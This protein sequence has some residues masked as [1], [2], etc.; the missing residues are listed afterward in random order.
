MLQRET[1]NPSDPYAVHVA[2]LHDTVV[3]G[4]ILQIISAAVPN[5]L[6]NPTSTMTTDNQMLSQAKHTRC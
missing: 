2:T 1:L 5:I 3:I 4:H 6:I